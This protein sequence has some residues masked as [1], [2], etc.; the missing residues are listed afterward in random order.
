ER[1][2]QLGPDPGD[3][4]EETGPGQPVR[5]QPG[6]PHGAHRVG[7]GRADADGEQVQGGQ[8]HQGTSGEAN[9][10]MP[11]SSH[12]AVY[13]AKEARGMIRHV[14]SSVRHSSTCTGPRVVATAVP[15]AK[16]RGCRSRW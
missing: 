13:S 3:S 7:R 8:R 5:E 11:S 10:V 15:T 6:G 9:S 12:R 14:S 2:E 1:A 4:L 16:A